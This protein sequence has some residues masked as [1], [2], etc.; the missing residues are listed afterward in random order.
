M[1][2]YHDTHKVFPFA[3]ITQINGPAPAP[4]TSNTR[5]NWF[6][7]IL[8]F[9][10]Q[11]PLYNQFVP[12]MEANIFPGSWTGATTV[13]SMFQCPSDGL[14]TKV[15][16]Q[17]FHGNYLVCHGNN[18]AGSGW[19]RTNGLFYPISS[20]SMGRIKDGTT[21]TVM[22]GEIKLVEDGTTPSG[23][24]NVICGAPHDLRGRYHNSYH[25]NLTF[26]TLRPPNTPVGDAF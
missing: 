24:G 12:Q 19:A 25:G 18:H 2:N 4:G 7:M 14:G 9:M 11:A 26:T 22:F 17:G 23:V 20:T 3:T 8:P 5:Q 16:N 10:D 21:N 6:H 13:L 1:H 15:A